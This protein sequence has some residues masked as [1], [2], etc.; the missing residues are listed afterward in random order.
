MKRHHKYRANHAHVAEYD[1]VMN[2]VQLP[3][4][5]CKMTNRIGFCIKGGVFK[6]YRL[7]QKKYI[8]KCD[9]KWVLSL[10]LAMAT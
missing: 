10:L 2:N 9:S 3:M 4:G 8:S 1:N 5:S 7:R 6:M